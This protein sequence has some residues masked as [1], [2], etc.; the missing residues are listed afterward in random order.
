MADVGAI[1][2]ATPRPSTRKLPSWAISMLG[3]PAAASAAG[4]EPGMGCAWRGAGGERRRV[5]VCVSGE[6]E[7]MGSGGRQLLE[8]SLIARLSSNSHHPEVTGG[9]GMSHVPTLKV[10]VSPSRVAICPMPGPAG[11]C[12]PAMETFELSDRCRITTMAE[13]SPLHPAWTSPFT[14]VCVCMGVCLHGGGV[15]WASS[16]IIPL[17]EA[18]ICLY[19][20][21]MLYHTAQPHIPMMTTSPALFTMAPSSTSPTNTTLRECDSTSPLES[22]LLMYAASLVAT[23]SDSLTAQ[24]R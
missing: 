1:A 15:L 11:A 16:R 8:S 14:L 17:P 24:T 18:P 7:Y 4:R 23:G 5:Q 6:G 19:V 10:T 21:C 12:T 13:R 20:L 2:S 3:A 9:S 22:F